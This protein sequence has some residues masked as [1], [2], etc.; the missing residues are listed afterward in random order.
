MKF[1]II[2][3]AHWD[4]NTTQQVV[5]NKMVDRI[6]EAER[7]G[8]WSAWT[9]EHHF[10]NDPNY[11]PFGWDEARFRA[12]D[13]AADPLTLLT[14]A[15]ARTS[16]IRLGTGVLV[17]HFDNP[18]RIAERAAMLD[19]FSG[20]RLELGVGRGSVSPE[21]TVFGGPED[22]LTNQERFHEG[23]QIL[24]KSWSGKPFEFQGKYYQVPRV[25]VVPRP[26]QQPFPPL[27][28]ASSDPLNQRFAAEN[29]LSYASIVG[30]WGLA[31]VQ[32]HNRLHE[33][34][35]QMANAAGRDVSRTPFPIVLFM[36]CM[37]SNAQAEEIGEQYLMRFSAHVEG[38]YERQR[39]GQAFH[40]G[41]NSPAGGP[42][43]TNA[44]LEDVRALAKRQLETNL[45][46]SPKIIA[47][48]LDALLKQVPSINYV[49]AI[50]DAG[51]PPS[52]LVQRSMELFARE[53]APRFTALRQSD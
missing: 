35:V 42:S 22:P 13:L 53:V 2:L 9:T 30:A 11:L 28:I 31:H 36:C 18:L 41:I 20:G 27:F 7:L 29:G 51:S 44:K 46:G 15:A 50:T 3:T 25:E 33:Q 32:G 1:G 37:E 16:R 49:L 6:V 48:K 10:A 12:Y 39:R 21:N 43:V 47:E 24:L 4:G 26:L 38:H 17:L 19:I 8:Y 5:L 52:E 23:I 14:F 40:S 34:F 45:I